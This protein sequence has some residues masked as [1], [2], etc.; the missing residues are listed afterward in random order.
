MVLDLFC[1]ILASLTRLFKNEKF[2]S[3]VEKITIDRYL[4][5]QKAT[6]SIDNQIVNVFS[7]E[8]AIKTIFFEKQAN[9]REQ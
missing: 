2:H 5:C 8:S 4:D 9:G 6:N 1:I 3:A 7:D